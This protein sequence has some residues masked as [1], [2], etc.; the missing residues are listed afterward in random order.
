MGESLPLMHS[1][2][3]DKVKVS[4]CLGTNCYLKGSQKVLNSVLRHAEE[5]GLENRLDVRA[6]FCFEKCECGPTVMIDGEHVPECTA[7]K[8]I[9]VIN[10]RLEGDNTERKIEV[11][12]GH[13][14]VE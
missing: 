1:H 11:N 3:T 8:A 14:N 10:R 7:D 12:S 4:V 5:K 2:D 6:G 13:V 9:E